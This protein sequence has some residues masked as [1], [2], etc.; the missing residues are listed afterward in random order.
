[1]VSAM[2]LQHAAYNTRFSLQEH[3]TRAA[4]LYFVTPQSAVHAELQ[5]F[6]ASD[7]QVELETGWAP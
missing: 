2:T 4:L 7:A 3:T 6:L 1:M 5:S